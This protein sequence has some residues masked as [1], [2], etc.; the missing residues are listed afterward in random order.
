MASSATTALRNRDNGR[1]SDQKHR[2]KAVDQS[3][4]GVSNLGANRLNIAQ[5]YEI[6][7]LYATHPA[8]Q[9]ARTVLHAQLFSGGLTL[10]RD[11]KAQSVKKD[12]AKSQKTNT[13]P[14]SSSSPSSSSAPTRAASEAGDDGNSGVLEAFQKHLSTHWLSFAKDVAD[15]F[16]KWG[17]AVVVFD[18]ESEDPAK[19][20]AR[21]AKEEEGI[22]APSRKRSEPS[23]TKRLIPRVPTLGTY[24]VGYDHTGRFG[25][26]REFK[27]Y[28][29]I[30]GQSMQEDDQAVVFIRQ[31]PDSVGNVNSPLASVYE[32]GSFVHSITE[33]AMVAEVSRATPQ[34]VTQLRPPV[35]TT[36]L[37]PGA[38]FFDSE[39]R[40]VQSGQDT[41]ESQS[42]AHALEMQAQLCR[43]INNLQTTNRESGQPGASSSS[44]SYQPPDI[45]PKLFTIPKGMCT[46]L[47]GLVMQS[48]SP[49]PRIF[50]THLYLRNSQTKNSPRATSQR[51]GPI[52]RH[53]KGL[54]LSKSGLQWACR[55]V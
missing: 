17:Y 21:L 41:E 31:D 7:R 30:P 24:E 38:L 5:V 44:H 42:A 18:L 43:I 50:L 8:V 3:F 9:A 36:G 52:W 16:L 51:R 20:A 4:L 46:T 25:Y 12:K 35:K 11:G 19:R 32:L 47:P 6:E 27:V 26:T 34:I 45:Q 49:P 15:S 22:S 33:L 23:I 2:G 10:F 40:N 54:R 53:S 13:L 29:Q 1:R 28:A 39:S 37:D 14:P 48:N 55:R